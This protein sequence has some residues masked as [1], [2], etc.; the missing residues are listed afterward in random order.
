MGASDSFHMSGIDLHCAREEPLKRD[1]SMHPKRMNFV[2]QTLTLSPSGHPD[3]TTPPAPRLYLAEAA[4]TFDVPSS[5]PETLANHLSFCFSLFGAF[6]WTN[7]P[8]TTLQV[9]NSKIGRLS[10]RPQRIVMGLDV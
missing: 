4:L 10:T 5:E 1:A 6:T 7:Y 8:N 9:Y 2:R 3:A